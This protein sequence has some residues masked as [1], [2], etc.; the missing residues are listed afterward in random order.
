MYK[1]SRFRGGFGSV[2]FDKIGGVVSSFNFLFGSRFYYL[3]SVL[4]CE[5]VVCSFVVMGFRKLRG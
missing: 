1:A 2:E 4:N 3:M 5:C